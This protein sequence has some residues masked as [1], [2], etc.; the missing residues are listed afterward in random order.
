MNETLRKGRSLKP[1]NANGKLEESGARDRSK[2]GHPKSKDDL[3]RFACGRCDEKRHLELRCF[4][5]DKPGLD[6]L[7]ED[8]YDV[9]IGDSDTQREEQRQ[10]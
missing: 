9:C 6:E 3:R 8:K 7:L 4:I 1:Y 5:C 10:G 2:G